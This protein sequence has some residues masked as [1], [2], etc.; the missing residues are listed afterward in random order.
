MGTRG[1]WGFI[2]GERELLTYNHFDS[3]PGGLGN[4]VL[5]FMRGV[6]N[7]DTLREQV[8][9]LRLVGEDDEPSAEDRERLGQYHEQVSTGTD[10]Y[11][12]L[13]GTQGD[14]AETLKAGV[15]LEGGSDFAADSLFCEWGY[16]IDLDR[17]VLEVYQGFQTTQPEAG[18][19]RDRIEDPDEYW[20]IALIA[21]Y[22]LGALPESL[23][24]LEGV[25]A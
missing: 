4:G 17:E 21:S 24:S 11:S 15:M 23:S 12:L 3:Y 2:D 13:R 5:T 18:R 16:V 25:E 22:P 20:P 9:G 19:F 8:R 1:L 6:D 14:P 7:L 10:W